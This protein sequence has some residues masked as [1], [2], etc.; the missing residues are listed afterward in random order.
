MT[1]VADE[2][3]D[4]YAAALRNEIRAND[5]K[6]HWLEGATDESQLEELLYHAFK[7]A[8]AMR[9]RNAAAVLHYAADVGNCSWFI[10]EA[11]GALRTDLL[12]QEPIEYVGEPVA[13]P[14]YLEQLRQDAG[15][16]AW[17]LMVW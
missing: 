10:A 1:A 13:E 4:I 12:T 8:R 2:Q 3:I 16:A 11:H 6:G 17:A 7:L 5:F 15:E 14:G 9:A